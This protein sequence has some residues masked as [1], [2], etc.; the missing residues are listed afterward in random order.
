MGESDMEMEN[1][2]NKSEKQ[3]EQNCPQ[4]K[5]EHEVPDKKSKAAVKFNLYKNSNS[6]IDVKK[7]RSSLDVDALELSNRIFTHIDGYDEFEA[8]QA[9]SKAKI[10]SS[11]ISHKTSSQSRTL[12]ELDKE[13]IKITNVIFSNTNETMDSEDIDNYLKEPLPKPKAPI[14]SIMKKTSFGSKEDKE[15]GK[16]DTTQTSDLSD[17][18]CTKLKRNTE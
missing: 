6:D 4:K 14:K 17:T 8:E 5:I 2:V 3:V 18:N 9:A 10:I 16:N 1:T 13:A 7:K 11:K 12:G 15:V